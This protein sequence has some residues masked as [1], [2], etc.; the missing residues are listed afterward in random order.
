MARHGG[1]I[2]VQ[3]PVTT[4]RGSTSAGPGRPGALDAPTPSPT[5]DRSSRSRWRDPRL[6]LGLAVVALCAVLGARLLAGA[7]DTVGVWVAAVPLSAGQPVT[8]ADLARREVRFQGVGDADRYVSADDQ[9]PQGATLARPVGVGEMLPR[10]A[11]RVTGGG[12]LTEVPLALGVDA[13]PTSVRVGTTVDVWVLPERRALDEAAPGRARP[14]A[15]SRLVF[16]DVAV[17]SAPEVG[18]SLGPATTRSVVIG[19]PAGR[20]A[21]LAA[22]IAALA[23]GDLLLTVQQ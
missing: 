16:D 23:D 4:G 12:A 22:S 17:V 19:V 5:A 20:P 6:A 8:G 15:R 13:V 18:S 7:D 21:R 10:A 3:G 11:L 9:L 2:D 14:A 1:G